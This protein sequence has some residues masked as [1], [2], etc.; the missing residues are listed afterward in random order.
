[1]RNATMT[2]TN[3]PSE[4]L[5]HALEERTAELARERAALDA[6]H[7]ALGRA[8]KK[9]ATSGDADSVAVDIN[10]TLERLSKM[11]RRVQAPLPPKT[12]TI[13]GRCMGPMPAAVVQI[14]SELR[15]PKPDNPADP[16]SGF[17]LTVGQV[18]LIRALIESL[19]EYIAVEHARCGKQKTP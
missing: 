6:A 7:T 11:F 1:M 5:E 19:L 18:R 17:S 15:F 8:H 9:L 10:R 14:A 3:D 16:N 13:E 2:A 12:T 4:D